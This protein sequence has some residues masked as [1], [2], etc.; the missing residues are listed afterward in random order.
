MA[1][2]DLTETSLLGSSNAFLMKNGPNQLSG[3]YCF[4]FLSFFFVLFGCFLRSH[5]WCEKT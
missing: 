1:I 2:A 3:Q 5:I 4:N